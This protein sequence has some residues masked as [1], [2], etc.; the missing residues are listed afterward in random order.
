MMTETCSIMVGGAIAVLHT[1]QEGHGR[2]NEKSGSEDLGMTL[3]H[4]SNASFCNYRWEGNYT[5]SNTTIL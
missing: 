1:G 5:T 2:A 4:E 3:R